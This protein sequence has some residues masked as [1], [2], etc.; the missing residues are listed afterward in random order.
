LVDDYLSPDWANAAL[1]TIDTQKDFTLSGAPAEVAGTA[2]AVTRMR[3]L[4]EE[5]RL[6]TRPIIHVVRIYLPD[7][8]NV[9]LCRRRDV[10]RGKRVVL[11]D[12]DGAELME[13]LKPAVE[14]RLDAGRLLAGEL[15]RVGPA[16]WIMYKP[17]WGAFH[18]TPLEDHLTGLGANTVVVCG[19]NFPNCPRAT[20]YE[21]SER[22]LRVVL[23][24]DATSGLYARGLRELEN[25]GVN[26]MDVREVLEES[27]AAASEV[28]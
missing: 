13:D 23:V 11:P 5:F 14:T 18:N 21:A 27:R 2:E 3:R 20:V 9:D 12:S 25:I 6:R 16:E 22:D 15:Q 26:L 10:E 28:V 19:C 7:G 8:S 17:R 4:V 24:A 1:L